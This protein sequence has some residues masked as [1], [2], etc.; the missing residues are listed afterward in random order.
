MTFNRAR[1][2]MTNINEV[3]TTNIIGFV[4]STVIICSVYQFLALIVFRNGYVIQ[5]TQLGSCYATAFIL[6]TNTGKVENKIT[7]VN[8]RSNRIK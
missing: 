1:Y 5:K 7:L 4:V 2:A 6:K 8:D 3:A